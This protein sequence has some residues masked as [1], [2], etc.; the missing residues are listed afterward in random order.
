MKTPKFLH[1]LSFNF[2]APS[3]DDDAKDLTGADLRNKIIEK[4]ND[5]SDEQ[6]KQAVEL[7][8]TED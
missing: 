7:W 2:T 8:D 4:L 3:N 5:M 6:V 1:Y